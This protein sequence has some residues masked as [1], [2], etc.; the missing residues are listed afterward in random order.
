M[1]KVLES[2]GNGWPGAVSRSVDNVIISIANGTS[3]NIPFGVPVFC[4]SGSKACKPF[5]PSHASNFSMD[6]FL[7]ITVRS[8]A[9]TP[10]TFGSNE[11]VYHPGD[12]VEVLV[13]GSIVLEIEDGA[14]P[15]AS[16]YIR[17]SDGVIVAEAG[18][19]GSTLALTNVRV[20]TASDDAS[21]SEVTVLERNFL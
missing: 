7:G 15:G 4:A 14:D 18:S 2:F 16:V 12:P 21:R 13:R 6:N 10:E 5:D 9:K 3:G 20:S 1:G 19:S 17:K 8:G 11:A